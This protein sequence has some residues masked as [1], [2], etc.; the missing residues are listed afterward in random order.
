[1]IIDVKYPYDVEKQIF[2][3]N[4]QIL[5]RKAWLTKI[6]N[7]FGL[8]KVSEEIRNDG[9]IKVLEEQ[10]SQIIT[11]AL[12]QYLITLENE[13]DKEKLKEMGLMEN[14]NE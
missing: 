10:I 12:P 7:A 6:H 14:E 13:D 9:V 11:Y 3:I 5:E 8:E 4:L 2:E 1:M